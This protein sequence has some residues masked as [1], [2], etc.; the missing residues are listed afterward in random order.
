[1]AVWG[2]YTH[3]NHVV[4]ISVNTAKTKQ[5]FKVVSLGAEERQS[6]SVGDGLQYSTL[7]SNY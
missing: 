3:L 6:M 4:L 5:M 1:M 7:F 2:D